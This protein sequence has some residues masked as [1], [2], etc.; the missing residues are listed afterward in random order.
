MI[1]SIVKMG[2]A[3]RKITQSDELLPAEIRH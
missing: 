1:S 3:V 2:D